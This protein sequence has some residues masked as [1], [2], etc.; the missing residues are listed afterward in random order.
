MGFM[1]TEAGDVMQCSMSNH[2][3]HVDFPDGKSVNYYS[4]CKAL[5]A[6]QCNRFV[7][8]N[9]MFYLTDDTSIY[10]GYKNSG[11]MVLRKTDH[12]LTALYSW[13]VPDPNF[14]QVGVE[15]YSLSYHTTYTMPDHPTLLFSASKHTYILDKSINSIKNFSTSIAEV[16]SGNE[17]GGLDTDGYRRFIPP[18]SG[19]GDN[20][21]YLRNRDR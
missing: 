8:K 14:V 20:T 9:V 3:I 5:C 15:K 18:V 17:L 19:R 11:I 6:P 13:E 4:S 2:S 7:A 10:L 16:V 21:I 12:M 1:F